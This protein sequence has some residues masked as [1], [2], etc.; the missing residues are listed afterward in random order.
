MSS[1]SPA[2][3]S[4]DETA[5]MEWWN[6]LG[7]GA[8]AY[9]L[10]RAGTA[11]AADA[12]AAYKVHSAAVASTAEP[13]RI[14]SGI[15]VSD[16]NLSI[17]L[18]P[19]IDGAMGVRVVAHPAMT[20]FKDDCSV[21]AESLGALRFRAEDVHFGDTSIECLASNEITPLVA[22]GFRAKIDRGM[23]A[24]L[25]ARMQDLKETAALAA[26]VARI[27]ERELAGTPHAHFVDS[28]VSTL[29]AKVV[30][31]GMPPDVALDAQCKTHWAGSQEPKFVAVLRGAEVQ[32]LLTA[33]YR[34][35]SSYFEWDPL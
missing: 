16:A 3:A 4:Q 9:W 28:F 1:K 6:S 30:L 17:A 24:A 29:A 10:D 26:A 7:E 14:F 8:R 32:E 23:S 12:W 34:L 27:A 22:E 13:Q 35:R 20:G 33:G 2:P 25:Q 18:L 21:G 15:E 31:D 5:G 19:G 11:V